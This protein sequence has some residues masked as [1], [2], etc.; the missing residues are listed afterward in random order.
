MFNRDASKIKFIPQDGMKVL[1][2]GRITVYEAT[3]GYQVY[4]SD[5]IEDGV[6]NL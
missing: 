6:G 5:M 1:L 2:T 4:V 3:G